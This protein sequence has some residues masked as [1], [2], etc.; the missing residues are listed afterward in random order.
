[1]YLHSLETSL[2]RGIGLYTVQASTHQSSGIYNLNIF[3]NFV[4]KRALEKHKLVMS[5]SLIVFSS[6]KSRV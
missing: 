4:Q 2:F 5:S 3:L 6:S 1:M